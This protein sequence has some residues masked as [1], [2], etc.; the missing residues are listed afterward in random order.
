V[1]KGRISQKRF[2]PIYLFC[3]FRTG[4]VL[5]HD[6]GLVNYCS[7]APAMSFSNSNGE[8]SEVMRR[9]PN[10]Q[11]RFTVKND[12][13]QTLGILHP[14]LLAGMAKI[15]NSELAVEVSA[16]GGLGVIG[17]VSKTPEQLQKDIDEIKEGLRKAGVDEYAFGVDL[18]LPQVGGKARKTNSDYTKGGLSKLVDIICK[19]K[20]RLFISAVGVPE[21]WVVEKLHNAGILY[22]NMVGSPRNAEKALAAGADLLVAQGGEAGGHCGEIAS[23]ILIPQVVRLARSATSPLT[24]KPVIVVGAGGIG[25]GSGLAMALS[26]GAQGG[27]VGTAFILAE[28]SGSSALH[29]NLVIQ[30]GSQDTIRTTLYTGRPCRMVKNE[31]NKVWEEERKE[32]M[33]SFEKKGIVVYKH[34]VHEARAKGEHFPLAETYPQFCGQVAGLLQEVKPARI[35]VHEMITE[36]CEILQEN[37]AK[38]TPLPENEQKRLRSRI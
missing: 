2:I 25:D 33:R 34:L 31:F 7:V 37:A 4:S 27:W 36:C 8:S 10:S 23:S 6:F 38:I 28:E 21:P 1:K 14:I 24:G 18:L 12:L 13:T 22:A 35:I 26:L 20:P 19:E 30:S 9:Q 32:E 29:Q 11:P 16:A 3:I 17:G 15:A 5:H